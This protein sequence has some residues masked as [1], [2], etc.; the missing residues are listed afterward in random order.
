MQT[1]FRDA[2]GIHAD[3]VMLREARGALLASNIANAATPQFKAR[4]FD[5]ETALAQMSGRGAALRTASDRHLAAGPGAAPD[6]PGYRVPVMD[7]LDGNT[8]EPAVEQ[9]QFAEN[10]VRHEASLA[11]LNRRIAGLRSA[12]RG[13]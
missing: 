11:L 8:V 9:M 7:S 1:T 4:D 10:T 6:A 5:F 3:A 13:E 2:L 12:I